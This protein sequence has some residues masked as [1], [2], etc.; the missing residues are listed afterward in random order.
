MTQKDFCLNLISEM[1]VI[2]VIVPVYNSERYLSK[3]IESILAQTYPDFELIL[4]NDGSSD[5]SLDICSEHAKKDSRIIIIDKANG[6]VSSAR[7]EGI[8]NASGE[9]ITF[10]DSDDWVD[11]NYLEELYLIAKKTN[12][13]LI[14]TGIR[15]IYSELNSEDLRLQ[16]TNYNLSD[17][18][19]FLS[20]FSQDLVTSPV[21]KLYRTNII[22]NNDII[23][24][25]G[26]NSGEDR[27]FNLNY[28]QHCKNTAS[29]SFVGYNYRKGVS[30]SL[31]S[32]LKCNEIKIN[33]QY[34]NDLYHIFNEKD[35]LTCATR[36]Y[37]VRRL[38]NIIVDYILCPRYKKIYLSK[39]IPNINWGFLKENDKYIKS[40]IYLKVLIF[41]HLFS[42]LRII[43][44]YKKWKEQ[45]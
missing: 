13:D 20:A 6:G 34:W 5:A 25:L 10:I 19:D 42:L 44:F 24:P 33:V 16:P 9:W 36:E 22:L 3:C 14:S 39:E 15:Y 29:D 23:F 7:N 45:G 30:E 28:L 12:V 26:V 35:F 1:P 8:R 27:A 11:A 31:S 40:P 18:S 4:I 32:L 21:A 41:H 2:T 43:Y 17:P 38:Y 37:L